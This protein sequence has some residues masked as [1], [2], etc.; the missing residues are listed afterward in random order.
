[1]TQDMFDKIAVEYDFL[2]NLISFFTHKIIKKNA[3]C[4]LK[5][6]KDARILD[7]CSGSGD[8]GRILKDKYPESEVIGADFS[9]EMLKIARKNNRD[10]PYFKFD[11]CNL[12]FKSGIF[13]CVVMGFGF[14]NIK[15]KT[16]AIKEIHRVLKPDG[17]FLHLDFGCKNFISKIY[18]KCILIVSR[19]FA[20]N[21]EA[22]FYLI[23]SKNE[24]LEPD[25]IIQ[26]FENSGFR[27]VIKKELLF[28]IIS[29]QVLRKAK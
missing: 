23:K 22:Y 18:D 27:K 11:A 24:F 19:F 13:D 28:G 6:K 10:I 26:I 4:A 20:K 1:M 5:I 3:L 21:K 14:R 16:S 29:Y 17:L 25:E 7:L 15:D 9:F 2:N 12:K 8:L